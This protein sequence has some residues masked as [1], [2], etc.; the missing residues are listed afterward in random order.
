[1][2]LSKDEKDYIIRELQV[3]LHCKLDGSRKNLIVPTCPYCGK[4]GSKYGI[5]VGPETQNKKPFMAHCFKCGHSTRTLEELLTDIGRTDLIVADTFDLDAGIDDFSFLQTEE[6]DID[7]EL[8]VIDM[9][10]EYKRTYHNKYLRKRGFTKDDYI[11]FPVGTTRGLNFKFDDYV[12]FPIIDNGDT[13]G[14]VSRHIWDKAEID[15]YNR[16]AKHNGKFQIMRYRNS[17]ENDFVKL[18]YNYDAI[19]EDVTDTV[20]IVEGVFDVIALTRKL[21]LY[22]KTDIAVVATFGKKIS[23]AQIFKLQCKGVETVVLGYDGDASEA[24]KKTAEKLNEYFDVYIADI[25]DPD[26]DFDS[27]DFWQ[28]YDTFAF[29]LKS[30]V[31]YKLNKIQL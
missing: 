1:M 8:T 3:E 14:Y 2:N 12:I 6:E 17:T 19:I 27:M 22:N 15:E 25:E 30:V 21:N 9:P 4:G 28:V 29:N 20:I 11:M 13:V 7:D 26:Q 10:D 31:E 24:I 5:Y 18:L 16:R 23:D